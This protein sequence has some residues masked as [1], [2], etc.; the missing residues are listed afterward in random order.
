MVNELSEY[1][2]KKIIL[3][4]CEDLNATQTSKILK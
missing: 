3:C 1:K 2:V 4:F